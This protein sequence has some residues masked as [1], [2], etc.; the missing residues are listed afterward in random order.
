MLSLSTANRPDERV[1]TPQVN[2]ISVV[3]NN[4]IKIVKNESMDTLFRAAS[5]AAE[6][7]IL[8]SLVAGREGRKG[9]E[10]LRLDG[11]PVEK[12]GQWLE[13]YRVVV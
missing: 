6:E 11:F 1:L 8:N 10:G 12:V 3:E 5:E 2:G 7:S 9:F 13:R 4:A